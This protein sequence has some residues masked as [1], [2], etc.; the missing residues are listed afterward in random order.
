MLGFFRLPPGAQISFQT[1]ASLL[2]MICSRVLLSATNDSL[3][4]IHINF[5]YFCFRNIVQCSVILANRLRCRCFTD[6]KY[7]SLILMICTEHLSHRTCMPDGHACCPFDSV[8][9][10]TN[11]KSKMT[12]DIESQIDVLCIFFWNEFVHFPCL[13]AKRFFFEKKRRKCVLTAPWQRLDSALKGT[14]REAAEQCW[15]N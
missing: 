11:D 10:T 5:R 2:N 6:L 4:R 3:I 9:T 14:Q 15:L 13:R 1:F 7:A 8:L 12:I